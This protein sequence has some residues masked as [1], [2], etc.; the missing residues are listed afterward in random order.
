MC[1]HANERRKFMFITDV[2]VYVCRCAENAGQSLPFISTA[3]A[4][5]INKHGIMKVQTGPTL[6][7]VYEKWIILKAQICVSTSYRC[8]C[9]TKAP[10][11]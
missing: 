10:V 5:Q 7:A 2:Y 6:L 11:P 3:R 9:S 4:R 1:A 8:T